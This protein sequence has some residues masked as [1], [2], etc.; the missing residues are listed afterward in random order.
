MNW[1]TRLIYAILKFIDGLNKTPQPTGEKKPEPPIEN[2]NPI[3]EKAAPKTPPLTHEEYEACYQAANVLSIRKPYVEKTCKQILANKD[4]YVKVQEATRVPWQVVGA[5]HFM[6][7]SLD[8][9]AVLHNGEKIIGTG[10]KTVLVPAG[11]G[12]FNSWHEA[13]I[14]A[15][16]HDRAD[17]VEKWTLGASLEFCERYNGLGY[18]KKGLMSQY[19]WSST[20]LATKGRYVADGKFDPEAESERPGVVSILKT[21]KAFE[22]AQ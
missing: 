8:M 22:E 7:A 6:E 19:L 14:D 18:R 15:L 12:P 20:T 16:S 5:I 1:F 2:V 10:R 21:L 9:R 17:K 3:K 4:T 11:K 13:A